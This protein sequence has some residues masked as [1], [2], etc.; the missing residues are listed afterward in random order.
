MGVN[1]IEY[2]LS[3]IFNLTNLKMIIMINYI[4]GG[5]MVVYEYQTNQFETLDFRIML[6]SFVFGFY[7]YMLYYY[8]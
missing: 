1:N 2:V 6:I 8:D 3:H 4:I 7:G 5:I